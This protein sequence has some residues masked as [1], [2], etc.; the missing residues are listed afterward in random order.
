MNSQARDTGAVRGSGVL[1]WAVAEAAFPNERESGDRYVVQPCAH[2]ILVAVVDGMGHGA[3][4]A[5]A[6][7]VAVATLEAH[8]FESPVA[9]ML[10]CHDRLKETR[11]AVMTLAFVHRRDRTLTWLGVGNVE[12]VLLHEGSEVAARPDWALLRNGVIGYRL[13]ALR[14]EQLPLKRRDTLVIVTDGIDPN[15]D[16]GLDLSDAPQRMADGILARHHPG[17]DDAL[18]LVARYLGG[19]L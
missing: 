6:A 18:V 11:G 4:A 17:N 19:D 9:L 1:E 16:D 14:A 7:K 2:G 12:A 10:R 5:A 8:A 13:P 3:E 15:F